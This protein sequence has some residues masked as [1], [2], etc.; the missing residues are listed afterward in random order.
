VIRIGEGYR[1]RCGGRVVIANGFPLGV[2]SKPTN[3]RDIPNPFD[4]HGPFGDDGVTGTR[5]TLDS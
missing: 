1:T 4:E 3:P 5:P 2:R